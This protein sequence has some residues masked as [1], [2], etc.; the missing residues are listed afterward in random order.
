MRPGLQTPG[1]TGLD[2]RSQ[3]GRYRAI[4]VKTS[5][6]TILYSRNHKNFDKRFPQIMEARSDFPADTVIDS[7]TL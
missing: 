1:G 4:G 6:E 7:R 3:V 5:S 2:L